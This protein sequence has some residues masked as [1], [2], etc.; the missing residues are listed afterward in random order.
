MDNFRRPGE[1]RA[2]SAVAF[3][4]DMPHFVIKTDLSSLG[5]GDLV[6]KPKLGLAPM[7]EWW[8]FRNQLL[9][10]LSAMQA[11]N[12]DVQRLLIGC[13]KTDERHADGRPEFVQAMDAVLSLQEGALSLEAPAIELTSVELIQASR[14]PQ[15]IVAWAHSC[16]ISEF[17][18]GTC[19]GCRKHYETIAALGLDPY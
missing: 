16:H 19:H 4:F 8:P 15:E 12:I 10:S 14:V 17:A 11:I 2:A 3:H 6:G 18:C 7:P 9:I 1:L 5:S 13:V